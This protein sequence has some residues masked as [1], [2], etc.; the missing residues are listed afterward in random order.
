MYNCS[1][2]STKIISRIWRGWFFLSLL[3]YDRVELD[4]VTL[5]LSRVSFLF[6]DFRFEIVVYFCCEKRSTYLRWI[7]RN[8]LNFFLE[9]IIIKNQRRLHGN[10]AFPAIAITIYHSVLSKDIKLVK[11]HIN[12]RKD[13]KRYVRE[14]WNIFRKSHSQPSSKYQNKQFYFLS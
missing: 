9:I 4:N 14:M 1:L 10:T 7:Q 13:F 2:F 5:N 12:N 11:S 6:V 3:N 8:F